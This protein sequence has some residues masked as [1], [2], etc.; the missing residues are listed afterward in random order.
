MDDDGDPDEGFGPAFYLMLIL[1]IVGVIG[2]LMT[3]AGAAVGM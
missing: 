1:G 3:A 2:F